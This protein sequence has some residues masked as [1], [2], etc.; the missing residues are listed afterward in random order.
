VASADDAVADP[1]LTQRWF[2]GQ[3]TTPRRLLW[4]TRYP[5]RPVPNCRCVIRDRD[6][7]KDR[8]EIC[9]FTR[10]S[11]HGTFV[12]RRAAAETVSA[13][14]G[15]DAASGAN[16]QTILDMSHIALLAAPDNPRYGAV[17]GRRDCLHYS[18]ER[19]TPEGLVCTGDLV[20]E[21]QA[22]VRYGEASAGNL[23]NYIVRRLTYNPDFDHM[24]TAIL[25]FLD[26]ND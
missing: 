9:A 8:A 15:I 7:A 10:P 4:Y 11:S 18:W 22:Y 24:A 20:D 25:E 21:G 16:H 13:S 26:E 3:E 14:A 2:C 5:D 19:D 23:R 17:S 12:D 1:D 6:P